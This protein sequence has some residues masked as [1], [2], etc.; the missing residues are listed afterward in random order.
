M[1]VPYISKQGNTWET[2]ISVDGMKC[3]ACVN[4]IKQKIYK[5]YPNSTVEA[6]YPNKSF[7]VWFA[8]KPNNPVLLSKCISQLGFTPRSYFKKAFRKELIHLGVA[9]YAAGN[10]MLM[11]IAEYLAKIDAPFDQ[12]FRYSCL[13]L[14]SFSLIFAAKPIWQSALKGLRYYKCEI[15]LGILLGISCS[16][17]FSFLNVLNGFG[18]VYFDSITVVVFLILSGRFIRNRKIDSTTKQLSESF[19]SDPEYS[20]LINEKGSHIVSTAKLKKGDKI[21]VRPGDMIPVK[22]KVEFGSGYVDFS[23]INGESERQWVKKGSFLPSGAFSIDGAFHLRCCDGGETG[24][25]NRSQKVVDDLVLKKGHWQSSANSVASWFV[26]AL[27]SSVLFLILF[28]IGGTYQESI[29]RSMALLLVACPCALGFGIPLAL[30][31]AIYELSKKGIVIQNIDALERIMQCKEVVFDKT[32]TL[33]K[34][35]LTLKHVRFYHQ[36]HLAREIAQSLGAYSQHH[37][38]QALELSNN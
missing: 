15:D 10:V 11:S 7:T 27:V 9:A 30:S 32:G 1:F 38:P 36:E 2:K 3:F 6:D 22:S 35:D 5:I 24:F 13:F 25:F 34:P 8:D 17:V 20:Y 4:K 26:F 29:R 23:S 16:Y 31:K 33:T 28:K 18:E 14:C 19:A 12:L 21:L 37:V